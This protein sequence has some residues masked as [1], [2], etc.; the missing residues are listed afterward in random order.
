MG[1]QR[2]AADFQVV[3][4]GRALPVVIDCVPLIRPPMARFETTSWTL[5]RAAAVEPTADSRDA[6]AAL[7][8]RY[9]R[10]VYAFVRRRGHGRDESQDLTQGFFALLIEKNYL[11]DTDPRRGR[12]RSFILTAVKHFLANQWDRSQALKRGGGRVAVS[13]DLVD[14]EASQAAIDPTT[15][16]TLFERQWALSLLENVMAKLRAEF[17]DVGKA[18]EFD[19][20]ST[21]LIGD[22][23]AVRYETLAA[24]RGVTAGALRIA[25]H[26]LRRRFRQLL[27]DEVADT[28]DRP[29][30]VDDE[31]RFLLATLDT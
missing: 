2:D 16:E 9:W 8:Q 24:E 20:L 1:R 17:A 21:F 18:D 26:R 4:F 23:D 10:P 27:R 28:V 19:R 11:L 7:C 12:F 6:L 31:L 13:I 30:D 22:P 5:V 25:V 14:V 3:P 29:E 15:P